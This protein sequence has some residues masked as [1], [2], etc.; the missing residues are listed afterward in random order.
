MKASTLNQETQLYVYQG[1]LLIE[2]D[3]ST[4]TIHLNHTNLFSIETNTCSNKYD[5]RDTFI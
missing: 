5:Q 4:L 2:H 1:I 3:T